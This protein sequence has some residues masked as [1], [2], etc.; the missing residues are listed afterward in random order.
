MALN[1]DPE[2]T[3][4]QSK[5]NIIAEYIAKLGGGAGLLL[6]IVLFIMFLVH[7]PHNQG[8]PLTKGMEFLDIFI[9]VVTII[10]VAVPEG[11][12]LAVT[13]ALAFA[14]T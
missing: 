9:V 1:D 7:L 8:S 6:F 13:L 2:I 3:P 4:L 14:T 10:V 5:L 12:P 11:L